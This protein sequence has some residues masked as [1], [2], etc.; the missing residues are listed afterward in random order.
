LRC[1]TGDS[2]PSTTTSP[3]LRSS[4]AAPS[5]STLPL[6]ISVLGAGRARRTISPPTT[7]RLIARARP[8]ASPS[9]ASSE[10]P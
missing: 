1:C 9:L 4:I 2:A 10:R 5:V 8:I 6:P 3:I 7:S